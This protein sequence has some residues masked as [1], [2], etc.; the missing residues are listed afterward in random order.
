MSAVA[1]LNPGGKERHKPYR[2]AEL[3]ELWDLDVSAVLCA[4]PS[5]LSPST[6]GT[7]PPRPWP[8]ER[9]RRNRGHQ[10]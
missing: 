2:V 5:P 8:D 6:C 3:A 7:S 1:R 9:H 4:F 10:P